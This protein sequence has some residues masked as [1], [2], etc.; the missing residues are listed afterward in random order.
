MKDRM[1]FPKTL[2]ELTVFYDGHC[3]MCCAFRDWLEQQEA[4]CRIRCLPYQSEDAFA[5]F[6]ELDLHEPEKAMLTRTDSGLLFRGAESWA[7][8]LH[9]LKA[10]R[11]LARR[12]ASPGLLPVAKVTCYHLSAHRRRLG[13]LLF[14][15]RDKDLKKALEALPREEL[16]EDCDGNCRWEPE[17]EPLVY[18]KGGRDEARSA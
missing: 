1:Q 11:P 10:Y 2:E 16:S 5:L 15:K 18:E 6:P 8:C 14:W 17:L 13:S 4:Y 12:L 9:V 7:L 3:A